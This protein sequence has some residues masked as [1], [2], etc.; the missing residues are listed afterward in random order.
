M[1]ARKSIP[2]TTKALLDRF[3]AAPQSEQDDCRSRALENGIVA[4]TELE[5]EIWAAMLWNGSQ[6]R[7]DDHS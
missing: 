6:E 1:S 2:P 3:H 7:D 5:K 4:D